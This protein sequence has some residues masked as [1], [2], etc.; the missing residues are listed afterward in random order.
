MHEKDLFRDLR[1]KLVEVAGEHPNSR[2]VRV[3]VWVGPLSHVDPTTL[4]RA[5]AE[6]VQGTAAEGASLLTQDS[7]D[8]DGT[9]ADRIILSSVDLAP[10]E[11]PPVW[12]GGV[13]DG[14]RT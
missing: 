13:H 6:I 14:G 4:Q 11:E 3:R 8:L 2:I 9:H 1:E 12:V 5:W 7:T 10:E